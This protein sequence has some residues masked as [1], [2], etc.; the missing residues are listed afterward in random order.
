VDSAGC[1][2]AAGSSLAACLTQETIAAAENNGCQS[3]SEGYDNLI[4]DSGHK[5]EANLIPSI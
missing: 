5:T 1:S 2:V 3:F 4:F